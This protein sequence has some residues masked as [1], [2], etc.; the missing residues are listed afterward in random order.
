MYSNRHLTTCVTQLRHYPGP[1][2]QFTEEELL[3]KESGKIIVIVEYS[4]RF[5]D[6]S[7]NHR[8]HML[9]RLLLD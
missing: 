2:T 6:Y 3:M 5:I 4:A 1:L 7:H 9:L 8:Y